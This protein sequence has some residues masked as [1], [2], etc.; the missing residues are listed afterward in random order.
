MATGLVERDEGARV[1]LRPGAPVVTVGGR[2]VLLID[3]LALAVA[4]L[5]L[6][7][8]VLALRSADLT[9]RE[10]ELQAEAG[11]RAVLPGLLDAAA[12]GGPLA[13][14]GEALLAR[15][16]PLDHAAV[17]VLGV[18]WRVILAAGVWWVLRRVLAPRLALLVPFSVA[19]AHPLLLPATTAVRDALGPLAATAATVWALAAALAWGRGGRPRDLVLVGAATAVG[20]AAA[21][22]AVLVPLVLAG[23]GVAGLAGPASRWARAT[24]VAAAVAAGGAGLSLAAGAVPPLPPLPSADGVVRTGR[25]LLAGLAGGPWSWQL[26]PEG[27][28]EPAG[29]DPRGLVA[30]AV[31]A[32]VLLAVAAR[33]PRRAA[34]LLPVVLP[35]AAGAVWLGATTGAVVALALGAAVAA[36][37]WHGEP[38]PVLARAGARLPRRLLAV[39][40]VAGGA[41]LAA[42]GLTSVLTASAAAKLAASGSPVRPWLAGVRESVAQL[43]PFPRL[44]PRPV[45]DPVAAGA[46]D[47]PLLD[48]PLLRLLRPD[49]LAHDAD[50]PQLSLDNRGRLGVALA[51]T[52]AATP[53]RGLCVVTAQP[54][55]RDITWATPAGP[56]PAARGALTRLGLLVTGTTRIEVWVR[57]PEGVV[58][59]V[60]SWSG[61]LLFQGP[62]TVVHPVPAGTAVAAVGVRAVTPDAG[63]CVAS[64]QVVV[65]R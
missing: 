31:V 37:P 19:V 47:Q 29:A 15:W 17:L 40:A 30:G 42:A 48:A 27:R 51:D 33:R 61:D 39:A 63:L 5:G 20:L 56:A 64:A 13:R 55:T 65:P 25:D 18:A 28:L 32:V 2:R 62:H 21:P 12:G 26:S 11:T 10:L 8:T 44:L 50:G 7:V 59:P 22:A 60:R 49:V 16:A 41:V 4:V 36:L 38:R 46:R 23:A 3:V 57:D 54:G 58:R 52:L 24:G 34:R 53:P 35:W 1:P 14:L 43:P 9:G 6:T 45:P